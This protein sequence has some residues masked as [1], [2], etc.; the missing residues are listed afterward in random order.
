MRI[1][2]WRSTSTV[3]HDQNEQCSSNTASLTAPSAGLTYPH[4]NR[5][6]ALAGPVI[7]L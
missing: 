6:V 7:V 5:G 3:A 1:P 4:A 2:V